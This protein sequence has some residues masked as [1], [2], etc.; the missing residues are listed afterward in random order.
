MREGH[1]PQE[2]ALRLLL[3]KRPR[4]EL[5]ILSYDAFAK[6]SKPNGFLRPLVGAEASGLTIVTGAKVC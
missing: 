4:P 3:R 5:N 2:S 6:C 1:A